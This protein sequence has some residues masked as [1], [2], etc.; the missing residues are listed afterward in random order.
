MKVLVTGAKGFIGRNLVE[1]LKNV[2]DQ[3]DRTRNVS[4]D[5]IFEYDIDTKEELLKKYCAECDFVFNLAGINRPKDAEEFNI[6]HSFLAT[7]L[8][9]LKESEN[10]CPVMLSSS[11][12]ALL[13]NDY[14]KSKKQAEDLLLK[15]G[16]DN[17]IRVLVYRFPN[18]FGK[19]CRPNY[20]RNTE[21]TLVYIDDIVD[22]MFEALKGN[23]HRDG[24]LCCVPVTHRKT[25]GEIV[26]LLYAFNDEP[27]SLIMPEIGKGSFE[28]KL[29]STY[30]S[31][32]PE[33]KVKFEPST[34]P[35]RGSPRASTGT[36]RSGNSSWSSAATA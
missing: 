2:R 27:V 6:N 14:G 24:E 23:E 1:N 17:G 36:I 30:L 15:Y 13:D 28:K 11:T 20:N 19:W 33:R 26:D 16:K 7:L 12:Q 25:L 35:D 32:L 31:Y 4:I 8:N 29:Y 9:T 21:L 22:E 5:E 3:K 18:V 10:R 34:F